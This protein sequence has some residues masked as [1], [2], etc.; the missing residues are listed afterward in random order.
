MA[1][2]NIQA[3]YNLAAIT[4]VETV[5]VQSHGLFSSGQ[6]GSYVVIMNLFQHLIRYPIWHLYID[7]KRKLFFGINL[8]GQLW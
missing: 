6:S 2:A 3:Y 8:Q 1:V 4:V 5:I 7:V